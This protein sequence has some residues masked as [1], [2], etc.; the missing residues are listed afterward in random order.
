[1]ANIEFGIYSKKE[2]VN[3]NIRFY[4]NKIDINA[5]TNI[6]VFEKDVKLKKIAKG[7]KSTRT[8]EVVND[9]VREPDAGNKQPS[10]L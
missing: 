6:F 4:H 3:L 2:P 8:V 9:I 5:K 10:H 1:M 7:K